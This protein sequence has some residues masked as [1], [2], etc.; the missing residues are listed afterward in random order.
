VLLRRVSM[1]QVV[2]SPN[3]KAFV[4]L[5]ADVDRQAL[6][7]QAEEYADLMGRL[8]AAACCLASF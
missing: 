2:Y 1:G 5:A 7:I 3:Y 8:L 6:P 4:T